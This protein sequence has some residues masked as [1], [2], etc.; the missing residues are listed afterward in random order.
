MTTIGLISDTHSYLDPQLIPILQT[1]DEIW[2]AGDFGSMSVYEELKS[3]NKIIRGVFG[4]IDGN[5]LRILMP[6]DLC[7]NVEGVKILMTHI[8][9][10]PGKYPSRI[11][12]LL[13]ENMSG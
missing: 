5:D 8:G 13:K 12:S 11:R 1:C 3:L 9:G 7:W 6:E 10:Y 4:N 2:H